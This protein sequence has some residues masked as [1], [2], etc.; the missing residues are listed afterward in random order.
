MDKLSF[1][2]IRIDVY[3]TD[4]WSDWFDGLAIRNKPDEETMSDG[5][6][7]GCDASVLLTA[8]RRRGPRWA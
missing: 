2:E 1:Y 5:S 4:R 8:H 7:L 3:L 6:P